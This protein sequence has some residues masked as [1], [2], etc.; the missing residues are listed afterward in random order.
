MTVMPSGHR[1]GALAAVVILL[2]AMFPANAVKTARADSTSDAA[3]Y[4]E[5]ALVRFKKL[6]YQGAIVQLRNV[7]QKDPNNLA[8]RILLGRAHLRVGAAAAAEKELELA[9]K[10]G[11]DEELIF[12]ALAKSYLLQRKFRE[13]L[14]KITSGNREQVIEAQVLN[15]RASANFELFQYETAMAEFERAL[16]LAPDRPG[17][18][19]GQAKILIRL[20]RFSDAAAKTDAAQKLDPKS[21]DVW[22]L[23]GELHRIAGRLE[24]AVTAYGKTLVMVPGH[25]P[26][27][28]GRATALIDLDR[29]KEAVPDLDHV[30][31]ID[32]SDPQ[33]LFLRSLTYQ[34]FGET[35]RANTSLHR[36]DQTIRNYDT[37][38][39]R[40]HPPTLLLAGVIANALEKLDDARFYL[41]EYLKM[42]PNH[43]GARHL[44]G[45]LLVKKNRPKKAIEVLEPILSVMPDDWQA[46]ALL[47]TAYTRLG[48][49]EEATRMLQ[50]AVE[51]MPDRPTLRTRLALSRL[52][53]GQDGQ[54]VKDLEKALKQSPDA[55]RPAMLLGLLHLRLRRFD[56]TIAVAKGMIKRNA[57]N[58]AAF[59]LLGG[60]QLGAGARRAARVSFEKAIALDPDFA[61][62][63][64]NLAKLDI[65]EGN[66][67]SAKRRYEEM[68]RAA[69]QAIDPMI[70]LSGLAEKTGDM[71]EAI[72]WLEKVGSFKRKNVKSQLQLINL[73]HR[74]GRLQAAL[75]LAVRL[76]QEFAS[77]LTV[78]A[79]VGE[80]ELKTGSVDAA[81]KTFRR[82]SNMRP[83][84]AADL[85]KFSPCKA[86]PRTSKAPSI[87]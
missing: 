67:E 10:A 74:A 43:L 6:D 63:Q 48:R 59:N 57:D 16:A 22:A 25:I 4:Y 42:A 3:G 69:P 26:A 55:I 71:D 87:R 8:A 45:S 61:P 15:A 18:L 28:I 72:R 80:A 9:R 40:S 7:L 68:L 2:A 38:F 14:D 51:Q 35:R 65:N 66:L 36:A 58:P 46:L 81:V 1:S 19:L 79:A 52:A 73:Y 21:Y 23:R 20:G 29:H 49:S 84:S 39:L 62:A 41:S 70:A 86:G 32:R 64:S 75:V 76:K 30:L 82:M 83:D 44:L 60:A 11:A 17:P 50:R 13:L 37:E 54:A 31:R 33:A 85:L 56:Q 78:L 53:I 24:E 34:R 5:D 77:D 47:G 12:D 27:R